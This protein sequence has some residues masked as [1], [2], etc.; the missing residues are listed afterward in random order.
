MDQKSVNFS[1]YDDT[2][3]TSEIKTANDI[4]T[5]SNFHPV[6]PVIKHKVPTFDVEDFNFMS[7]RVM[8]FILNSTIP[9]GFVNS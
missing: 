9:N 5:E 7:P 6:P 1:G 3:W 2:C 4:H 8:P